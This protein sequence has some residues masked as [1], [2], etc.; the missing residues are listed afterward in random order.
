MDRAENESVDLARGWI[1]LANPPEPL[2]HSQRNFSAKFTVTG[3][4]LFLKFD[5]AINT[6]VFSL[7][8]GR[9]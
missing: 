8:K 1:R 3:K 9:G 4:D 5:K 7:K 2:C 6:T